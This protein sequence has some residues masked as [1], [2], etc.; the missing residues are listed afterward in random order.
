MDPIAVGWAGNA[1][2][3]QW[4]VVMGY[5]KM[6]NLMVQSESTELAA[7]DDSSNE[8][9]SLGMRYDVGPAFTLF[10][11]SAFFANIIIL[12]MGIAIIGDTYAYFLET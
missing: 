2:L 9:D 6:D 11:L 3:N 10:F 5:P 8:F 1:M 7:E 12:N 4:L